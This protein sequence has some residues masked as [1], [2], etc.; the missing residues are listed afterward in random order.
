MTGHS[1]AFLSLNMTFSTAPVDGRM[2]REA[3][4]FVAH[5]YRQFPIRANSLKLHW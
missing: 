3:P 4:P 5:H 2:R 1:P